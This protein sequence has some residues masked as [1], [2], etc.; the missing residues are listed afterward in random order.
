MSDII[1]VE[2]LIEVYAD[3]T[4]ALDGISFNVSEGEFFGFL[5][6]TAP[7]KA[8]PSKSSLP[9]SEKLQVMLQWLVMIWINRQ[10]K[11]EKSSGF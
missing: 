11:S 6:R 3:G 10:R 9:S 7:E 8:Q 1:S 4:K 5:V 2:N